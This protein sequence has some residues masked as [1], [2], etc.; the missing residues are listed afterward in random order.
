M[1]HIP[2]IILLLT[3]A[4]RGAELSPLLTTPGKVL[5]TEEFTGSE[6]PPTFRTLDSAASF[7]IVDGALQAVSRAGQE[8]STHGVF[9]V[10][11]HDLTMSFAMKFVA[12]GVLYIGVD[13]YKEEFKGNTHLVR[14]SVNPE[15]MAW[16]QH[17]GGPE[18]KH[19][20]SE[21]N[22]AARAAKQPIPK[23]TPEQLAD[24]DRFW[25]QGLASRTIKCATGEWHQVMIEVSGNELVAQVDGNVVVATAKFADAMKNRIGVGFTERGTV[26]IDHVRI[27]E[28]TRR[29]DWEQVKTKL[30]AA[31]QP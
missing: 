22:R 18:Q 23:A 31:Q 7:S 5:L 21:A 20:V 11:A 17:L 10:K 16:D 1:K 30:A 3:C 14:F 26:L 6:I 19:A 28:N 2:F 24:P 27:T 29:E 9:M 13:G 4:T 25:I 12:P 15:H 8:R